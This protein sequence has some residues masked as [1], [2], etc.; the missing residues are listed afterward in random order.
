MNFMESTTG[1]RNNQHKGFVSISLEN[2]F[3]SL[4]RRKFENPLKIFFSKKNDVKEQWDSHRKQKAVKLLH[5][6]SILNR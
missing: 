1:N 5:K 6:I 2:G 3:S 4:L